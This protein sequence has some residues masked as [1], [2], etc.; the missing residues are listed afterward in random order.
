MTVPSPAEQWV[1]DPAEAA[2]VA[3]HGLAVKVTADQPV[4][5]AVKVPDLLVN[6]TFGGDFA[7]RVMGSQI[8]AESRSEAAG[9]ADAVTRRNRAASPRSN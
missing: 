8:T 5:V 1:L 6:N 9:A 3:V 7:S 4:D 2:A